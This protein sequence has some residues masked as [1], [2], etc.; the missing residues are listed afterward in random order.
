MK[1]TDQ[2]AYKTVSVC[3]LCARIPLSYIHRNTYQLN[4]LVTG[5]LIVTLATQLPVKALHPEH[6]NNYKR[7]LL[8]RD[9]N[10]KQSSV[11]SA[12]DELG[13]TTLHMHLSCMLQNYVSLCVLLHE[14]ERRHH[15]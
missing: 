1:V 3:V 15:I 8:H 5:S 6:S 11:F 13:G 7:T 9:K 14:Q 12:T 4:S 2:T 10:G